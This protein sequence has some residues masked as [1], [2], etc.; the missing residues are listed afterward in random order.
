MVPGVA[1]WANARSASANE[2]RALI[3][4]EGLRTRSSYCLGFTTASIFA[5]I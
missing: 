5:S 3:K 2:K 1:A 4:G